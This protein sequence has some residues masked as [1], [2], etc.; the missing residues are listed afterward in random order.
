LFLS[1]GLGRAQLF[2]NNGDGTFTEVSREAGIDAIRLGGISFWCDYDNDG[3]LDLIRCVWSPEDDVF[4]TLVHGKRPA[5]GYPLIL[6]HNNRNG[7]FTAKSE[8]LG[9]DECWGTMCANVGDY[10]NDGHLDLLLGNG[11]PPMDHAEPAI[12]Y[13]FQDDG[14]FHNVSFSAGLPRTGKGHGANFADLAGDGRLCLIVADG[15]MY[16]G[17]LLTTVVCRP[18]TLPGNYLNVRLVG[19]N[20]NRNAIGARLKLDA[21]GRSQHRAVDGGSSFGCLPFEQHFGLAKIGR[22]DSL[23]ILWPSGRKQQLSD[24][25]VNRTIRIVEGS[26]NWEDVYKRSKGFHNT[27]TTDPEPE[28]DL[29]VVP[30]TEARQ[31]PSGLA[32]SRKQAGQKQRVPAG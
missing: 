26:P 20:S 2:H 28:A 19:T 27:K 3:W 13:E 11:A 18:E 21:G 5:K 12:L 10:N 25:P 22:V 9:L 17:D 14:K 31:K 30:S 32:D 24:L 15:G 7:T 8:E 16:P 29:A 23:E 6:Y 4:H 1:S